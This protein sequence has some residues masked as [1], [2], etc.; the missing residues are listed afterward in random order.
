MP[1]N[2]GYVSLDALAQIL[3]LTERE[4]L[5]VVPAARYA[6]SMNGPDKHGALQAAAAVFSELGTAY[7]LIGGLVA[8]FRAPPSMSTL[9]C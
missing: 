2:R 7:A 9:R 6:V 3:A 4:R 5:L 1:Y 8:V